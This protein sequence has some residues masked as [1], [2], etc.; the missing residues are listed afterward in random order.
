[1]FFSFLFNAGLEFSVSNHFVS[2][3]CLPTDLGQVA[4]RASL[5]ASR[6][7]KTCSGITT[8]NSSKK[9]SDI[10]GHAGALS[11]HSFQGV[12]QTRTS[13]RKKQAIL[14]LQLRLDM[15][16]RFPHCLRQKQ[17]SCGQ[18]RHAYPHRSFVLESGAAARGPR[19]LQQRWAAYVAHTSWH[20]LAT[21]KAAAEAR[22]N[23]DEV[24]AACEAHRT[25]LG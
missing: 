8:C 16:D 19:G 22:T 6:S 12:Q 2:M 10:I 25:S 11:S 9:T 20:M 21:W 7:F 17:T 23:R 1:M 4:R 3:T 15:R 18:L 5:L 24:I 14:V 13:W